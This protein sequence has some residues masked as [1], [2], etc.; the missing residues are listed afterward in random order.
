L[1]IEQVKKHGVRNSLLTAL[2]P[3]ATTSQIMGFVECF[4]PITSNLYR[5]T[6]LSGEYVVSNPIL[7]EKLTALGLWNKDMRQK[8]LA[9][10]GSVQNI[11]EVPEH[12][13]KVFKTAFELKLKPLVVQSIERGP[14][15]DQ[16][17]SLNLFMASPNSEQLSSGHF[18]GWSRGLKTGMYYLRSKPAV[19]ALQFGIDAE[20][21]NKIVQKETTEEPAKPE[22]AKPKRVCNE[23]F[24]EMCSA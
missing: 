12:L 5:R 6:T 2:M 21:L 13:K 15:I 19:D 4:E 8:L 14:F 11:D 3:T 23:H 22:P 9:F 20:L 17:Q 1:L 18:F 10:K 16:S 24:C 7:V